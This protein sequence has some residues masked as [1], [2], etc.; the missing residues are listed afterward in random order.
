MRTQVPDGESQ[1]P[2]RPSEYYSLLVAVY[3]SEFSCMNPIIAIVSS[4]YMVR[5]PVDRQLH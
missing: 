1:D 3:E 4:I 5:P 2:M